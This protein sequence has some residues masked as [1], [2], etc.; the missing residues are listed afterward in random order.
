MKGREGRSKDW[1]EYGKLGPG[2]MQMR[3]KG[4]RWGAGGGG[5]GD[6][7]DYEASTSGS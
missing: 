2:R 1:N 5:G 3:D 7:A 6:E 4:S